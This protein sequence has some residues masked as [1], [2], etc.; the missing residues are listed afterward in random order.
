MNE[1]VDPD[2]W[3][4]KRLTLSLGGEDGLDSNG[5]IVFEIFDN[6]RF[7]IYEGDGHSKS[8]WFYEEIDL[9]AAKLIRDFL[10]YAIPK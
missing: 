9:E 10:I 7:N 2:P 1:D 6:E 5:F 8:K 3:G 4:V